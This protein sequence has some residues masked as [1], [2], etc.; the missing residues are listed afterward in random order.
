MNNQQ[1]MR[2]PMQGAAEQMATHGRYGDSML[3]HMN[4]VEVQGLASLSPTGSLTTNPMTGQPEAFLPFLA[5]LLGSLAGSSLLTGAA[6]GGL[7]GLI[8]ATGLSSAAAGAI[9][10]GLATTAITG[11]L[12]EGIM[13]GLTGFGLGKAFGAAS[14][15]LSPEVTKA[16]TAVDA[17]GKDALN[18]VTEANRLSGAIGSDVAGANTLLESQ[19]DAIVNAPAY[20]GAPS[21]SS[22]SNPLAPQMSSVGATPSIADLNPNS[23]SLA[24]RNKVLDAAKLE[25]G[26]NIGQNMMD[27]PMEFAKNFGKSAIKSGTMIPVAVGEGQRAQKM[28]ED[29][30]KRLNEQF[31]AKKK[32]ELDRAYAVRDASI[33]QARK[34]YAYQDYGGYAGGGLVSVDPQEYMR[35]RN[36]VQALGM[37][38][39]GPVDFGGYNFRNIFGRGTTTAPAEAQRTVRRPNVVTSDQ[40]AKEAAELSAQG[41]DPRAG[42]TSEINYFRATPEEAGIEPDPEQIA[43]ADPSGGNVDPSDPIDTGSGPIS[44]GGKGGYNGLS[45]DEMASIMDRAGPVGPNMGVNPSLGGGVK[46][47]LGGGVDPSLYSDPNLGSNVRGGKRS[48][49]PTEVVDAKTAIDAIGSPDPIVPIYD[50]RGPKTIPT[51]MP[52]LKGPMR[53]MRF[54]GGV[55]NLQGGGI[56][57]IPQQE[58]APEFNNPSL[59]G[60]PLIQQATAEAMPPV[61]NPVLNM[62]QDGQMGQ[63]EAMQVAG[64]VAQALSQGMTIEQL[65]PELA[66]KLMLAIELFG[67]EAVQSMITQP[68]QSQAGP[69]TYSFQEGGATPSAS[70]ETQLIEQTISAVLGQLPQEQADIIINQFISEFGQEA[71][72]MLR[73][74]ALQSVVPNA[75]TEGVIKGQGGG[76]DD[77]VDGM[78]GSEQPVAVSPGEYIVPADVVS[79]LGDGSTD[80]GVAELDGML[81]RVRQTRTGTTQQPAPMNSGGVL[82]A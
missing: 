27:N 3:V 32:A 54:A 42:F 59:S 53:K 64:Q 30:M 17:V 41:K 26:Q 79:G 75:Q 67:L 18:A 37:Y 38:D 50:T 43:P 16:A 13:S 77:M 35:Q 57:E 9:G 4:P 20:Q 46:P 12:K 74:Q 1:M 55:V 29:D 25:A 61:S 78:I 70:P 7:G 45:P 44:I 31:E 33:D 72:E 81:D 71:F 52:K 48:A 73:Q 23:G 63:D 47:S 11:N 10:S 24:Y 14:E 28:A 60:D 5:P 39:G 40:L 8:G 21:M 62:N 68:Q 51:P 65:P 36:G 6:A 76:M 69:P 58:M 56:A 2:R 80:G 34:D 82:P 49:P 19:A 22:V 66:Q 15:A